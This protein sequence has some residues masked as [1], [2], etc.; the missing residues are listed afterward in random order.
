M[1]FTEEKVI[2]LCTQI[3]S[4]MMIIAKIYLDINVP[5]NLI[6]FLLL[7]HQT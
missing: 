2:T 7:H 6:F 5:L 1:R 4:Q 3:V